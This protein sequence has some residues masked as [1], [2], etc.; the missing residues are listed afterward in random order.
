MVIAAITKKNPASA[1]T[2]L[3]RRFTELKGGLAVFR[4]KCKEAWEAFCDLPNMSNFS[5]GGGE[6]LLA[7]PRRKALPI[8]R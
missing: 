4:L 7:R 3:I 8:E 6:Q 1:S 2:S 5:S